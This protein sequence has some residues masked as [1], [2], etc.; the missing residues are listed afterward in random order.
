MKRLENIPSIWRKFSYR[1]ILYQ[2]TEPTLEQN[3]L[4]PRLDGESDAIPS[5]TITG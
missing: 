3:D 1:T 4:L 2:F 5:G